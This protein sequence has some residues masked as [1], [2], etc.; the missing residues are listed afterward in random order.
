MDESGS[1]KRALALMI[2]LREE[3]E[4]VATSRLA[5]LVRCQIAIDSGA[6]K[7]RH[8][9]QVLGRSV[10][11]WYRLVDDLGLRELA[12]ECVA[13]LDGALRDAGATGETT[14]ADVNAD[15]DLALAAGRRGVW[16]K[17]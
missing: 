3:S 17:P 5:V 15:P 7:A 6:L 14:L 1:Q 9:A 2:A 10:A 16:Q 4:A 12:A 8:V 13:E 11:A